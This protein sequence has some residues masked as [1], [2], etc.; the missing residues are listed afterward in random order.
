MPKPIRT[1]MAQTYQLEKKY[2]PAIVRIITKFR[3]QFITHYRAHPDSARAQL[4]QLVINEDIAKLITSIYKTAGL[5]GAKRQHD[6]L[7]KQAQ[8]SGG[9]GRNEQ[10]I[11]D[12]MDYLRTHNLKM[13]AAI[14]ETLREDIL[15][16][17]QKAVDEGWGI[18]Q[19][20]RKLSET[21]LIDARARVIARTEINRAS[22]V[23]HSIAAQSLPFEVDKKWNA[24]NDARTRHS[25]HQID[26]HMVGEND[27]FKV[28]IYQGD[29]FTGQYDEMQFPGDPTAHPSNTIN[30]RCRVTY[31]SKRDSQGRLILR[32][33]NEARII[34]MHRPRQIELPAI[35]AVLKSQIKIGVD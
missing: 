32:N 18:D 10:W 12:V 16:I 21:K 17:L 11:R 2:V 27:T 14:T 24:A 34:P 6:E 4:S 20:V 23:G 26:D 29:K 5:A 8:K 13:V 22:N 7:K 30:C 1:Y 3:K 25:H 19:V 35:A 9:L 15:K 33:P 28:K 31:H